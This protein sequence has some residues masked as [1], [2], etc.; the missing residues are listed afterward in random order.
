MNVVFVNHKALRSVQEAHDR[1]RG[2]A[3]SDAMVAGIQTSFN[4]HSRKLRQLPQT[5]VM[6]TAAGASDD[7]SFPGDSLK[8]SLAEHFLVR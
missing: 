6:A 3:A 8:R 5:K 2:P 4:S 1:P 7:S